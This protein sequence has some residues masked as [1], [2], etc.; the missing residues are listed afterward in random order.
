MQEIRENCVQPQEITTSV[1]VSEHSSEVDS[2]SNESEEEDRE[3]LHEA[4]ASYVVDYLVKRTEDRYNAA[5]V[6]RWLKEY[7]SEMGLSSKMSDFVK[8]WWKPGS[9]CEEMYDKSFSALFKLTVPAVSPIVE[10]LLKRELLTH[11]SFLG[12]C[13]KSLQLLPIKIHAQ[14]QAEIS[15]HISRLIERHIEGAE[16]LQDSMVAV[17]IEHTLVETMD[18]IVGGTSHLDEEMDWV[19]TRKAGLE[20]GL[21]LMVHLLSGWQLRLF[22]QL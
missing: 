11:S 15:A 21:G 5:N 7:G 18:A 10:D 13:Q 8:F 1:E 20:E 19:E 12:I 22:R 14:S 3:G 9:T 6:C 2:S 16:D 17:E 4:V